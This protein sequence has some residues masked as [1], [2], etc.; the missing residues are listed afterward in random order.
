VREDDVLLVT[1]A[2]LTHDLGHGPWSHMFD[3]KFMPQVRP[4][5]AWNHEDWSEMM[6][7]GI[8]ETTAMDMGSDDVAFIKR[9]IQGDRPKHTE[10]SDRP[11][12]LFDIV[13]NER[14][15]VDVDKFDYLKRDARS[16]GVAADWDSSRLLNWSR[17]ID[18]E[19]CDDD[20]DDDDEDDVDVDDD[21]DDDVD[22]DVDVVVVVIDFVTVLVSLCVL[23]SVRRLTW[24]EGRSALQTRRRTTFSSSS[25]PAIP[26]SSAS[27]PIV[28]LAPSRI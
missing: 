22:V 10:Y 11:V 26:C 18:S 27:T 7:D 16:V 15:G 25:T 17:V 23:L 9:L 5:H 14:N 28:W 4:G 1:L 13:S 2:G 20:N 19:V 21:D 24:F 12:F 8:L 6:I 3:G